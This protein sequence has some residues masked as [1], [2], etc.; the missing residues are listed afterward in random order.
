MQKTLR[1]VLVA[2]RWCSSTFSQPVCDDPFHFGWK[3]EEGSYALH[4][5]DGESRPSIAK[6]CIA[7]KMNDEEDFNDLIQSIEYDESDSDDDEED[8]DN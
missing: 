6:I 4:W 2:R 8:L 5:F 1:T 3:T 7:K